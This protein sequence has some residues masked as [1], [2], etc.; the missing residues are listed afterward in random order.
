MLFLLTLGGSAWYSWFRG[1]KA[2]PEEAPY[3]R[4][5]S[6]GVIWF[7]VTISVESSVIPIKDIIFEQRVYLPSVGFISSCTGLFM[8]VVMKVRPGMNGRLKAAVPAV[9]ILV[10]LSIATY[11]RNGVWTDEVKFWDDVVRKTGKAIGYNNR[12]NAYSKK[13]EYALALRDLNKAVSSFP[14][15]GASLSWE[16]ADFTPSNMSKTYISRGRVYESLGDEQR[17]EED[18]AAAKRIMGASLG[19]PAG[20]RKGDA[21]VRGQAAGTE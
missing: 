2:A 13:G 3:Y 16:D 15:P 1:N 14:R 19:S 6:I 8:L 11:A 17:A 5:I 20:S 9:C 4:L 7:F 10:L 21:A 18:F 12:G